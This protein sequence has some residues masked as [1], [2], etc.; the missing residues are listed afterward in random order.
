MEKYTFFIDPNADPSEDDN[1]GP[2][3]SNHK[4]KN[5]GNRNGNGSKRTKKYMCEF[6]EV[7]SDDPYNSGYRSFC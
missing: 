3:R 4:E 1:S 6:E 5:T 7:P 2:K